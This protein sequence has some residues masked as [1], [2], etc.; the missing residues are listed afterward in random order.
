MEG[1]R[2]NLPWASEIHSL[3]LR[4]LARII[5]KDI[6]KK[7]TLNKINCFWKTVNQLMQED[8]ITEEQRGVQTNWYFPHMSN[9]HIFQWVGYS[10]LR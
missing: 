4:H 10:A 9:G 6:W 2:R 7:F 1:G 8:W 3:S 5:K